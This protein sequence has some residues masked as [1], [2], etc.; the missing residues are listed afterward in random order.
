MVAAGLAA[1]VMT[2]G[3]PA[4]A[5]SPPGTGPSS[6]APPP[7]QPP[8]ATINIPAPP[9]AD[10]PLIRNIPKPSLSVE[11][12]AGVLGYLGGAGRLGPAWN[13]RVTADFTPR[14]AVEGNYVGSINKRSDETGSLAYTSFD[15]DLRY[16]ILRADEAPV[17]PFISAGAGYAG[18]IGPGGTPASL[19]L[20]LS[21]G[22]ERMLT[23][24][25][26]IGARLNLRPALFDD[27]G[28]GYERNPP[29][30]DAWVLLVNLGGGF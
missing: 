16:N 25:I 8:G 18:W 3:A 9:P 13:V 11:G 2:L 6:P 12:G 21:V 19:V 14:F 5:Q 1:S 10:R 7:A 28:H 22:V 17:Q 24:R 29:G 15:A 20:P 30:G 26:K 4:A 23:E 27:L